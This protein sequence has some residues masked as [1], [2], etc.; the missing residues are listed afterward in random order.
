MIECSLFNCLIISLIHRHIH[1]PHQSLHHH[2]QLQEQQSQ[3]P[4]LHLPPHLLHHP[5]QIL[6]LQALLLPHPP[7]H[8]NLHLHPH[9]H[10]LQTHLQEQQPQ[11]PPLHH[12]PH[13][14]HPHPHLLQIHQHSLPQPDPQ[15]HQQL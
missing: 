5:L 13:P 11:V 15:Q 6:K 8:Q 10:L 14:P 9:P 2:P 1:P 12:L 3:V 4:L 7:H